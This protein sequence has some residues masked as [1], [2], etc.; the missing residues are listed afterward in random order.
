MEFPEKFTFKPMYDSENP[1]DLSLSVEYNTDP[2]Y[3]EVMVSFT[4]PDGEL[5]A[6]VVLGIDNQNR[7]RI[8]TTTGGDGNQD[9]NLAIYPE[10]S[11][12]KKLVDFNF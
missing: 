7:V 11:V 6:D 4:T 8:M 9:H 1:R 10:Q 5:I 3:R 12:P 2:E